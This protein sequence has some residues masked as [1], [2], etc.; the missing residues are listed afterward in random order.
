MAGH[1]TTGH[2]I[3]RAPVLSL[4][5]ATAASTNYGVNVYWPGRK[6]SEILRIISLL[7][8]PSLDSSFHR[9]PSDYT[10]CGQS[11]LAADG[12]GGGAADDDEDEDATCDAL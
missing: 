8:R 5:D 7:P 1:A 9:H 4:E 12:G 6:R 2:V 11:I 3:I 10:L